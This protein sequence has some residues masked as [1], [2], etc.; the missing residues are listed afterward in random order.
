MSDG[1]LGYSHAL[2]M[3]TSSALSERSKGEALS[4]Q[5][6]TKICADELEEIYMNLLV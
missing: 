2:S 4:I 5:E 6:L 3:W 1:E